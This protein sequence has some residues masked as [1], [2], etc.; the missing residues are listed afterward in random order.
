MSRPLLVAVVCI[1]LPLAALAQEQTPNLE[2]GQWKFTSV[3]SVEGNLPIPE[4]TEQYQECLTQQ[5]I[6]EGTVG[7]L[8]DDENC[9]VIEKNATQDGLQ[10]RLSCQQGDASATIE[11]DMRYAGDRLDGDMRVESSTAAGN[12]VMNTTIE[13]QRLGDC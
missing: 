3:S 1:A 12:I 10:F 13:G 11:G 6:D 5:K 8:D 7:A 2:P 4:Q 9:S